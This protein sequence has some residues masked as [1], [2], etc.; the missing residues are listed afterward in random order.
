PSV[1]S[2][3]TG[4]LLNWQTALVLGLTYLTLH[5]KEI[6]NWVKSLWEAEKALKEV[7]KL[8]KSLNDARITA[9]SE[10][11]NQI[12]ELDRYLGVL[13]KEG[14]G[15]KNAKTALDSLRNSFAY[16][17]EDLNEEQIANLRGSKIYDEILSKLALRNQY[18]EKRSKIEE[19]QRTVELLDAE[20]KRRNE[21]YEQEK[22]LQDVIEKNRYVAGRGTQLTKEGQQ[23]QKQLK[24]L[25][26]VE[27]ERIKT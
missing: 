12:A 3:V 9:T 23:A 20:I 2:R 11:K 15:T 16:W 27:K 13:E 22:A 19:N 17:L 5:G 6:W 21:V 10:T 4:A 24:E 25:Q 7:E 8:T 1:I 18:V 14:T 26:E